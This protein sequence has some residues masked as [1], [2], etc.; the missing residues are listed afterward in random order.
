M[1]DSAFD[2]EAVEGVSES[3]DVS[4]KETH[5]DT[6]LITSPQTDAL[7][8]LHN[9]NNSTTQSDLTVNSN[10]SASDKDDNS[11]MAGDDTNS[12]KRRGPRT[13]IKAKQLEV[14]KTAFAATP[15]PTRHIREQLASETGLNM[16]VIQ[17]CSTQPT[18]LPSHPS[19]SLALF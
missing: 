2:N 13:T 16:R 4:D 5:F 7:I 18:P 9:N 3:G 12:N 1:D 6:D 15:K 11:S 8:D 19:F 17:V 10:N 14:L